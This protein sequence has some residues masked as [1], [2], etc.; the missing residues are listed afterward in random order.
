MQQIEIYANEN[1]RQYSLISKQMPNLSTNTS[2]Q[3]T[4]VRDTAI[5]NPQTVKNFDG[6]IFKLNDNEVILKNNT[7]EFI[8]IGSEIYESIGKKGNLNHFI[9]LEKSAEYNKVNTKRPKSNL[10]ISDY[11]Y[12][13]DKPESFMSVKKYLKGDIEGFDC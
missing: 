2:S 12:L 13:E 6:Q 7:E 1:L 9:K 4:S 11:S 8:K 3:L 5:N 10:D